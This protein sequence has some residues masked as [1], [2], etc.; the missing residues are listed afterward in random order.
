MI[1]GP[2]KD[3]EMDGEGHGTERDIRKVLLMYT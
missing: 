2:A 3:E 1:I